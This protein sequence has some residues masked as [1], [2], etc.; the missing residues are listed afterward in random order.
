MKLYHILMVMPMILPIVSCESMIADKAKASMDNQMVFLF[1]P[2]EGK[3]VSRCI[4][5]GRVLKDGSGIEG[6]TVTVTGGDGANV[7][8]ITDR[9]G[10]YIA[11]LPSPGNYTVTPSGQRYRMYPPARDLA[12]EGRASDVD[13]MAGASLWWRTYGTGLEERAFSACATSDGGYLLA[14]YG[15]SLRSGSFSRDGRMVKIDSGGNV[16]WDRYYG[17]CGEEEIRSIIETTAHNYAAAG[18]TSSRG[19]G[20]KD[21]WLIIIDR[22]GNVVSN[23]EHVF[24]GA[25]DDRANSLIQGSMGELVLTGVTETETAEEDAYAVGI[26]E[27]GSVLFEK[28]YGG[29]GNDRGSAVIEACPGV[30]FVAGHGRPDGSGDMD[31]WAFMIDGSGNILSVSGSSP[32]WSRFYGRPGEDTFDTAI[33]DVAGGFILG[34]YSTDRDK[35]RVR[36]RMMRIDSRGSVVW[37]CNDVNGGGDDEAINGMCIT[38]EGIFAV[39]KTSSNN[40]YGNP[41]V[42]RVGFEG[43]G[44]ERKTIVNPG[45]GEAFS[46]VPG[47]DG[48]YLVTGYMKNDYSA[49]IDFWAVNADVFFRFNK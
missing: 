47:C 6:V 25:G 34:G 5:S 26:S 23:R 39:G 20:G 48:T 29:G 49:S 30:Y 24:G 8:V 14:G 22:D 11:L 37:D 42:I 9:E 33:K 17:G 19:H 12:V 27:A 41:L 16:I 13:F 38:P 4:I 2:D 36:A 32:G 10:R 3:A 15:Y 1:R 21:A 40:F 43:G 46:I 7:T 45:D 44:L 18:Y 35:G 28:S 31:S